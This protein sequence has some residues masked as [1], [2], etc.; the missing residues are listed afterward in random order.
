MHAFFFL[1]LMIFRFLVVAS[2]TDFECRWAASPPKIDGKLD[3]AVWQ[4]AQLVDAFASAWLPEG[5]RKPPT[6]T[7]ARLLWDREYLYFAAEMEDTDVLATITEQ[8]GAIWLCDVFELFFKPAK[9]TPG[10]Y[11]F[12]VNAANA[13]LDMFLASRGS[14]GYTRH[15]RD[16]DFHIES[17]VQV[18]GTIN[19][20][21]DTDKGWTV[22]GRI[23]WRDFLPTGGRPAPGEVWMHS[24]CRYDYSAGLEN[25][26]LSTNTPVASANKADFHRYEDS[27]AR[28]KARRTS[29]CRGT[30]RRLWVR[31]SRRCRFMLCLHSQN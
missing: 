22:E 13:K 24:L 28:T 9:D 4:N 25:P 10:Y 16:R 11:E 15:A 8:D 26:A 1:S 14:G 29:A 23:P 17:A 2:A 21:S 5:E 30:P 27:S 6:A 31:P 12:E 7:K 20:W 19:N 3:D 18:R